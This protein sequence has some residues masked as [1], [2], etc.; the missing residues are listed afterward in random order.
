MAEFEDLPIRAE[1][2]ISA[3]D[4]VFAG[5]ELPVSLTG[6][7]LDMGFSIDGHIDRVVGAPIDEV[8]FFAKVHLEGSDLDAFSD[9]TGLPLPA[10]STFVIDGDVEGPTLGR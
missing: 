8:G 4:N 9:V 2:H 5:L 6:T 3:R 10:T 1:G 7:I